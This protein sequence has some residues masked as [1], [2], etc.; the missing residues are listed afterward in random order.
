MLRCACSAEQMRHMHQPAH[1][2]PHTHTHTPSIYA[3]RWLGCD[4]HS[5]RLSG[6]GCHL[7][8]YCFKH[9]RHGR[10]SLMKCGRMSCW[11]VQ[12]IGISRNEEL[13]WQTVEDL[14]EEFPGAA[15]SYKVRL[16]YTHARLFGWPASNYTHA[17]LFGWHA[18]RHGS[19]THMRKVSTRLT[20][21]VM[22]ARQMHSSSD[23]TAGL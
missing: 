23:G 21:H 5:L 19:A 13:A 2:L 20:A 7:P 18:P 4:C 3:G 10:C 16:N 11:C 12:V 22:R 6:S 1:C 14:R 9:L 17:G 8:P 15:I